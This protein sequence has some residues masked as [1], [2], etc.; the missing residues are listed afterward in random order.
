MT[1]EDDRGNLEQRFN[2]KIAKYEEAV[3][4]TKILFGLQ[5][6]NVHALVIGAYGTWCNRNDSTLSN[7]EINWKTSETLCMKA[8]KIK[9]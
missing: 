1:Y 5:S 7:F 4:A 6:C 2:A 3:T 8:L 9:F